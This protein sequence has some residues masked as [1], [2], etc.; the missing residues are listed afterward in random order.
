[1]AY[2]TQTM[3]T[4]ELDYNSI[5]EKLKLPKGKPKGTC[6]FTNED[7]LARRRETTM[8]CYYNNHG[9]HKLYNRLHKEGNRKASKNQD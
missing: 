9:F 2:T 5:Y 1:M 4:T 7:K 3:N 6:K 8:R